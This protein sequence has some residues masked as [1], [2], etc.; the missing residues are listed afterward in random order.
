M[1][2]PI[3][4]RNSDNK[5][6]KRIFDTLPKVF[7][8]MTQPNGTGI[9]KPNDVEVTGNT[10]DG[11]SKMS[12]SQVLNS[13]PSNEVSFDSRSLPKKSKVVSPPDASLL[14]GIEK[15]ENS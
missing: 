3:L 1:G 14:E 7:E 4:N 5:K 6:V 11:P 9:V 15:L 13:P 10:Q 8:K 12:W 2:F